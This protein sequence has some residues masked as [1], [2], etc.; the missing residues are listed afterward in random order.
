MNIDSITLETVRNLIETRYDKV[1]HPGLNV[2]DQ[3]I[4]KDLILKA[5]IGV[6]EFRQFDLIGFMNTPFS[7]KQDISSHGMILVFLTKYKFIKQNVVLTVL[8]DK[9]L[10]KHG[11]QIVSLVRR[12]GRLMDDS[13]IEYRKTFDLLKASVL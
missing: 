6:C 4:E 9:D 5:I 13:K 2:K 1:T 8:F 7:D 12:H 10:S 11:S 3:E